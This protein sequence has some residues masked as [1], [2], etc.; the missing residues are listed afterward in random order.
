MDRRVRRQAR[1]ASN[2]VSF[3]HQES[4]AV[5]S[6]AGDPYG[7]AVCVR[8]RATLAQVPPAFQPLT[9]RH[10][11]V[12]PQTR[13]EPHRSKNLETGHPQL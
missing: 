6:R 3:A 11:R 10:G 12:C 8:E 9:S 7:A 13:A 1:P 4:T 2:P 5:P